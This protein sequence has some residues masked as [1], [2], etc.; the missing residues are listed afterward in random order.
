M[1]QPASVVFD[2]NDKVVWVPAIANVA[3]PLLSEINAGGSLDLSCQLTGDG[4]NPTLSQDDVVDNRLCTDQNYTKPGRKG[5]DIPLMYTINPESP[6]DDE[7]RITLLEGAVGYFV[8]RPARA[9]DEDIDAWDWVQVW[10][11]ELGMPQ[12]AGRTA[13]G[14][15]IMQQKAHLRPPGSEGLVQVLGS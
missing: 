8:E 1:T 5:W 9:F 12:L 14:V 3:F 2:G 4:W 10:S 13:N 11:V 7:A 15:W 6:A